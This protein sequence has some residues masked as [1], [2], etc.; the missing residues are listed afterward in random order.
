MIL[1][2]Y[3]AVLFL[4]WSLGLCLKVEAGRLCVGTPLATVTKNG[5]FNIGA[6]TS[7]EGP[8]SLPTLFLHSHSPPLPPPH[9]T[10]SSSS[11]PPPLPRLVTLH[12][13]FVL[14]VII[15]GGKV[16]EVESSAATV[17]VTVKTLASLN[18]Q[19][20]ANEEL[21]SAVPAL[22]FPISSI[23]STFSFPRSYCQLASILFSEPSFA[24]LL[25]SPLPHI[26][27]SFLRHFS[28]ISRA[29]FSS[30]SSS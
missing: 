25:H 28:L 19:L 22:P 24:F 26:P 8:P 14:K 21:L 1:L 9:S 17:L 15:V 10:S 7:I 2:S 6:V 18:V 20:A 30:S 16:T 11:S 5:P 23:M 12:C 27:S 3:F 13:L 4:R 29:H